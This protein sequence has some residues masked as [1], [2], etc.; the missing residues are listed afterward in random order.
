MET[1]FLVAADSLH[2][3]HVQSGTNHSRID[4]WLTHQFPGYSRTFFQKLIDLGHVTQNNHKVYKSKTIIKEGDVISVY[5][6]PAPPL[7]TSKTVPADIIVKVL[8]EH[9][10]FLIIE[11]P[12]G[13]MVHAASTNSTAP[14]LV[15]WLITHFQEI[16]VVGSS[17]RPGIVHRLD[18]ETSGIMVIPRNN[19]AH[20]AFGKMFHN[21]TIHKEYIALV[22]GH[23]PR[24][25]TIT[26]PISRH[27][28]IRNK[29]T[30][31][32][33]HGRAA[34]TGYK[35]I[36]YYKD[37]SLVQFKPITGRTH[38]IRVHCAAIGHPII[39]D[40]L[41]GKTS[42]HINRHALHAQSLTFS[43]QQERYTFSTNI[44]ADIQT[45]I[46]LKKKA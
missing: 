9:P 17:D 35:V 19:T 24:E 14:T 44:P 46:D 20:T 10:D 7:Q 36:T 39:G 3:L 18:K 29:M 4:S 22:H 42:E 8:Y 41:Y 33:A 38:Q 12:A 30:H 37:T 34:T 27:P 43:H 40:K 23:P 1:K 6:P 28:R 5:F 31:T 32:Q 26:Y 16:A 11:K 13:L 2:T 45:I 15:D 21:R 25:G